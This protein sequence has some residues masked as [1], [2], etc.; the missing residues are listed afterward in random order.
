M[1]LINKLIPRQFRNSSSLNSKSDTCLLTKKQG[2]KPRGVLLEA[3]KNQRN[4]EKICTN[5]DSIGSNQPQTSARVR[6][7]LFRECE[8]RG[9][10]LIFD[11]GGGGGPWHQFKDEFQELQLMKDMV[12]GSATLKY[13]GDNFRVHDFTP[14]SWKG[15]EIMLSKVFLIPPL[16]Q[17]PSRIVNRNKMSAN[18]VNEADKLANAPKD[19]GY[20]ETWAEGGGSNNSACW[21]SGISLATSGGSSRT[22]FA[23]GSLV[24]PRIAS[25]RKTVSD[26]LL[27]N[28]NQ[29]SSHDHQPQNR[30]HKTRLA[31]AL[32]F[33]P[34]EELKEISTR[35]VVFGPNAS[36]VE[37]FVQRLQLGVLRAYASRTNFHN[38]IQEAISQF[39][40]D[41]ARLVNAWKCT[42]IPTCSMALDADSSAICNRQQMAQRFMTNW[43]SIVTE[44]DTKL[45]RFFWSSL[46]SA[47]LTYHVNWLYSFVTEPAEFFDCGT[48]VLVL[49]K[50]SNLARRLLNVLGYFVRVSAPAVHQPGEVTLADHSPR[51]NGNSPKLPAEECSTEC[52]TQI[53]HSKSMFQLGYADGASNSSPDMLRMRRNGSSSLERRTTLEQ[54]PHRRSSQ[55]LENTRYLRNYYDVRFQLSPDTIAKR[56]PTKAFANLISSIAKNGFHEFYT[57]ELATTPE[58]NKPVSCAFFVG[59]I[60]DKTSSHEESPSLT[61]NE[62]GGNSTAT[63]VRPVQVQMPSVSAKIPVNEQTRPPS[64]NW[65]YGTELQDEYQAG[66]TLQSCDPSQ[67]DW[68]SNLQLDLRAASARR[69]SVH[70]IVANTDTWEVQVLTCVEEEVIPPRT[71]QY[72][73]PVTMSGQV[74]ALVESTQLLWLMM[75]DA[76]QCLDH[77][78]SRLRFLCQKSEDLGALLSTSIQSWNID[79]VSRLLDIE[80]QDLPLLMAACSVHSPAV[81]SMGGVT[82]L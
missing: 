38:F 51:L 13:S 68:L 10:R 62:P 45:T 8:V 6:L 39:E 55:Q 2:G 71:K 20:V 63:S 79:R 14:V 18:T 75:R 17:Q 37:H 11:S 1:A 77:I 15:Y 56:D 41:M 16:A 81:N 49:S 53:C 23:S 64:W 50:D 78:E 52:P 19:S 29:G 33:P 32:L 69:K 4:S 43:E 47:L 40:K 82:I 5:G 60:P 66:K 48:R 72:W 73:V 30:N 34:T 26:S 24:I 21:S 42:A 58:N 65:M 35:E 36:L 9:R 46:L 7:L 25:G 67:K 59:S 80:N 57:E 44:T 74:A 12:F 54:L 31:M 28:S 3:V 76:E 22:S 27:N 70:C 61:G